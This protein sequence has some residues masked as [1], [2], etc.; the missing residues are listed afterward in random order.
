MNLAVR[1]NGRPPRS[2][3]LWTLVGPLIC[4]ALTLGAPKPAEAAP[5]SSFQI[6]VPKRPGAKPTGDFTATQLEI[7]ALKISLLLTDTSPITLT[8]TNNTESRSISTGAI[9]LTNATPGGFFMFEN[10]PT[11]SPDSVVVLKPGESGADP[12]VLGDPKLVL[13]LQLDNNIDASC[14][15]TML[16]SETWTIAVNPPAARIVGVAVQ[17][18]DKDLTSANP[19]ACG[20]TFRTTPL[21]SDPVATVAPPANVLSGRVGADAVL[22]LDRSGSMNGK[23]NPSDAGSPIKMAQLH[24]AAGMFVDMWKLLRANEA[25]QFIQAPTDRLGVVYFD[26]EIKWLSE[27][28]AGSGTGLG[29]SDF[30][31]LPAGPL[32]TAIVSVNPNGSTS[33]GGGIKKAAEAL[34][35]LAGDPNRKVILLMSDGVHNTAPNPSFAATQVQVDGVNL[36]NQPPLKIYSV[37][38]GTGVAVD[39]TI[40]QGLATT[41]G[42][43]YLNTEVDDSLLNDFFLQ[44]LQN[45]HKFATV[46]TL[47]VISD[48]TSQ[49]ALFTTQ[50]PV[51]TTTTSLAFGVDWNARQGRLRV[52]LTPPSGA[53][54]VFTPAAGDTPGTLMGSVRLP[55]QT[56]G[57]NAGGLWTVSVE[58]AGEGNQPMPFNLIVLGDDSAVNT[59]LG[60]VRA[61]HAVGGKIRL[62][63]RVNDFGAALRDLGTQPGA[64]VQAFVVRPGSSVGD[65]LSDAT[66]QPSGPTP[67][68]TSSAA[69]RKLDALLLANPGALAKISGAVTLVDDGA[70][71]SGDTAANDGEYSALVPADTEGHYQIVFFVEGVSKSGGRFVRQQIRTVHVRS[72]PDG[73]STQYAISTIGSGDGQQLAITMT[74]RNVRGGKMGPGYANYFWF[75]SPGRPPVKPVDNLNGTY[76][77]RIPFSGTTAPSVAVHFLDQPVIRLD[78]YVPRPGDLNAGNTVTPSVGGGS[79]AGGKYAIW[80]A[81]GTASPRG[82]FSAINKRGT[83]GAIG[84]EYLLNPDLSIEAVLV[85]HSVD[86]KGANPDVDMT[87]FGVNAK[88]YL[89]ASPTRLFGFV[90]AGLYAFDPGS[91]RF[92]ASI[93]AGLQW[94]FAP[95]WSLEGRYSLHSVSGNSPRNSFSSLLLGL[96]Y[97]F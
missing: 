77:A 30:G 34:P 42:G 63:A 52:R 69:Q 91:T 64:R 72:L 71:A 37:T 84:F 57:A 86:G 40:N 95:Q 92:G 81:L 68:D 28:A 10:P 87:Q 73:G 48:K 20:N 66:V 2:A 13:K 65:V 21:N 80:G 67:G 4:A 74:P 7:S 70:A 15:S 27:L 25:A 49:A 35:S 61:E 47:R 33:I 3:L 94:Q 38:V 14:G 82:S 88:F 51:T 41:T 24:K 36:A 17:T 23:A 54:I 39:P 62:V 55:L 44:V 22:V 58:N 31:P 32:K 19:P 93:G 97:A 56:N 53:P 78:S 90:G 89:T 18:L 45:F 6:T 59:T 75:A 26:N 50:V 16:A 9:D 5:V 12:G 8:V 85:A 11:P 29:L 1:L 46:E 79:G 60:V 76:T 83:A 96:R 43:F